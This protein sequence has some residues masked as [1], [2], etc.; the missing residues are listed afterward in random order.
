MEKVIDKNIKNNFEYNVKTK[1][2]ELDLLVNEYIE[3]INS[4]KSPE[5]II[6]EINNLILS[7]DSMIGTTMLSK[8][9]NKTYINIKLKYLEKY[10]NCRYYN[11]V[12]RSNKIDQIY[13][14]VDEITAISEYIKKQTISQN[15]LIDGFENHMT[16]I[17]ENIKHVTYE[18]KQAN[19]RAQ[20]RARLYKIFYLFGYGFIIYVIYKIFK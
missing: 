17:E 11:S 1:I 12:R 5:N 19:V 4:N 7:I 16:A 20:K 3:N 10:D 18:L 6:E 15:E 8:D 13:E 9:L 2:F 14:D